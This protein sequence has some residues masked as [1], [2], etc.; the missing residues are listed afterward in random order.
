MLLV[1]NNGPP[2]MFRPKCPRIYDYVGLQGKT[3]FTVE[4]KVVN[5]L[6]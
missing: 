5:Q 3:E 1:Q 2:V 6:T 4:I